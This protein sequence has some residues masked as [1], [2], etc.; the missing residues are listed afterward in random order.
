MMMKCYWFMTALTRLWSSMWRFTSSFTA[1]ISLGTPSDVPERTMNSEMGCTKTDRMGDL[2]PLAMRRMYGFKSSYVAMGTL[3]RK[4]ARSDARPHFARYSASPLQA[5]MSASPRSL[6]ASTL[7]LISTM[8]P[9][10][11]SA[12]MSSVVGE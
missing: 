12:A 6:T 4:V 3:A 1:G 7:V 11:I 10:I 8:D 2:S 9:S 5:R